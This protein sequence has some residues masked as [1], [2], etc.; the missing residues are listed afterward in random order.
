MNI[1]FVNK[2]RKKEI[3]RVLERKYG[4]KKR[5]NYLFLERILETGFEIMIFSGAIDKTSLNNLKHNAR[6][7][8]IGLPLCFIRRGEIKFYQNAIDFLKLEQA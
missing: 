1:E 8:G 6:V 2:S 5:L 4:I 7:E 3:L